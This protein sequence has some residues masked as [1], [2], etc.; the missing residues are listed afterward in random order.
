MFQSMKPK[1][2]LVY[3]EM[4][5]LIRAMSK[6]VQPKQLHDEQIGSKVPKSIK[7]LLAINVKDAK[8]CKP[9]KSIDIGLYQ[10]KMFF[11]R[12]IGDDI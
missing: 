2:H 3:S 6:F 10:G 9:L 11:C 1:I 5:K 8:N 12:S 7:Q 4:I